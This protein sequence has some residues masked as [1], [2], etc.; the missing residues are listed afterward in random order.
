MTSSIRRVAVFSALAVLFATGISVS[1]G[2]AQSDSD[3]KA[4]SAL[5]KGLDPDTD[6]DPFP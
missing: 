2:Y 5:P 1:A 3:D 6:I 4:V